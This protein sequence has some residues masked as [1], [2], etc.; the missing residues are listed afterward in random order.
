MIDEE[1]LT[2]FIKQVAKEHIYELLD[3]KIEQLTR[4]DGKTEIKVTVEIIGV[5]SIFDSVVLEKNEAI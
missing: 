1:R 2:D 4:N 3:L 5:G